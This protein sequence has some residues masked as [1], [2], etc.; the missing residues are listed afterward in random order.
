MAELIF[1]RET[2]CRYCYKCLRNCPV[3]AISFKSGKSTVLEEECVFCGLCLDICPQNARSYRKDVGRFLSLSR[4]FLVSIAPSFFAYFENPLRVIGIL[5]EMGAVVV[6]E[7]AVGAEIVS[8]RYEE[9]FEKHPGPL[10]TTA[11]PVVVNLAEKH[12]PNVLKYFAPVDSPLMAH[13]KFLK[14]RYGDFP[15]VFVGPCIAKKSESDLVDVAL[16]F[17]ELEEILEER[18]GKEALPDGPYPDRAR[19]YPTTDGIG[20]TVSV[21]WEKSSWLKVSKT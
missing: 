21:P 4:P 15:I 18:E 14:T 7:T 11:C 2:D 5:K 8:R 17:E 19:F 20:Y 13:A 16:T 9:V 10:I 1:S 6:Q 3:K 12:F